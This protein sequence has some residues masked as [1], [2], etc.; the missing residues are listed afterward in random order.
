[1]KSQPVLLSDYSVSDFLV[2]EVNMVFK[3]NKTKTQ[4]TTTMT[5]KPN[6]K[7]SNNR[8]PLILDG[9]NFL[10]KSVFINGEKL[11]SK[12]F[13]KTEKTIIIKQQIIPQAPFIWKAETEINPQGN[14]SLEGLYLS[15]N[16]FC[17]QCEPEGFRKIT[18]FLDRPDILAT[19][20]IRIEGQQKH[21][22][23][24]GNLKKSGNGWVEWHDPW[25]KPSYLFALVAG[26]LECVTDKF[27]TIS[28]KEVLLQIYVEKGDTDK[29]DHAM[30]SIKKCMKWDEDTYG[31]E[32]DLERF[33]IVAIH[34]F[35]MGAMENKGLNIFNSKYILSNPKI[36]TDNDYNLI[37][38]IIAHEYFHNWT[39]N[40][41]TCRD[42]FQ[43][44]L[45][46]GLTVFRDQ[47]FSES[48]L[49]KSVKRIDDV[50]MLR[51]R[52]FLEDEGPLR[53]PVRPE[54]YYEINNFYTATIYEKGA[55][56]IRMLK[57]IVGEEQYY[58][59][60]NEYFQ[61]YDGQACTIE[62]F[63]E[64]FE[65]ITH[66]D[67]KQFSLWY[68]QSGTP[69]VKV[70]ESYHNKTYILTLKQ[71]LP[72]DKTQGDPKP[73]V[74]PILTSLLDSQ[75]S[76]L[77]RDQL[78]VLNKSTQ[79]FIF[80]NINEK[81][82][83][84]LLRG[85]S[86]PINLKYHLS[87]DKLSLL[88]R[89]ETDSFNRWEISQ[90]IFLNLLL[91]QI[92]KQPISKAL[93]RIIANIVFE[94]NT[95]NEIKAALITL[96]SNDQIISHVIQQNLEAN[97]EAIAFA[98]EKI[99]AALADEL[100]DDIHGLYNKII[101]E[102][103]LAIGSPNS[104]KRNLKNRYL[105]I[106]TKLEPT[107]N[108]AKNALKNFNMTQK[109]HALKQLVKSG[110]GEPYLES[111]FQE[112]KAEPSLVDKWFAIQAAY[113]QP[114]GVIHHIVKLASHPSFRWQNPNRFRS[115]FGTFAF[116]NLLGFHQKNGEGY[117][118]IAGWIKRIDPHNPQ[119]AARLCTSFDILNKVDQPRQALIKNQLTQ[120][121]I[122]SSLSKD[123]SEIIMRLLRK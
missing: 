65:D 12:D 87:E 47:Q 84:S 64:V 44:C 121:T 7:S 123:T 118:L 14:I 105:E 113:C 5:I 82:I 29:C 110:N 76:E 90:K 15:N 24:N 27:H 120:L 96:P 53:H 23:S 17:T 19:Y 42:W 58:N 112:W 73:M 102:D 50:T 86:A 114:E 8:S 83:P 119:M 49:G 6:P 11:G 52:Q 62:N 21:L 31:R 104:G 107:A 74:I 10:L 101:I 98:R 66:R 9:E 94:M 91:N 36:S 103:P 100:K 69:T 25:P 122:N 93:L 57:L 95:K 30:K 71:E 4:V 72:V 46:E 99:E 88:L 56:I 70:T 106:I 22:L 1:M 37:Q 67:L 55:E 33:M 40:R 61:K 39:G 89:T 68:K 3:L 20:T 109:L 108:S 13:T 80:S 60:L 85:F 34:D 2:Q 78:L 117:K 116:N 41:I 48:I 43:L 63:L 18:Y 92:R 81:P 79:N 38:G 75:G 54:S 28:G 77:I 26:D 111:F 32:Y 16:I 97:P 115:L 59:C 35:N 51:N 45:K